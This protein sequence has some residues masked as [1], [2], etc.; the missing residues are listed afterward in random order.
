MSD[1][2]TFQ[3]TL[4]SLSVIEPYLLLSLTKLLLHEL[5]SASS[6]RGKS[7]TGYLEAEV[8]DQGPLNKEKEGMDLTLSRRAYVVRCSPGL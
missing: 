1:G 4:R 7:R 2:W 6:K 8:S 5:L 3:Q